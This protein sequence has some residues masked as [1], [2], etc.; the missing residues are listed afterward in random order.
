MMYSKTPSD[1]LSMALYSPAS[2]SGG[3]AGEVFEGVAVLSCARRPSHQQ[4]LRWRS[5]AHH[6]RYCAADL[7]V[8]TAGQKWLCMSMLPGKACWRLEAVLS[9]GNIIDAAVLPA[10]GAFVC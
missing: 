6:Y 8:A 1:L 3:A 5:E 7:A 9:L 10:N 2:V 4:S